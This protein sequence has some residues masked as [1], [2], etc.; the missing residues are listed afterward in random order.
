MDWGLIDLG[1]VSKGNSM[2]LIDNLERIYL[3]I[4]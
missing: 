4:I 2:K 3:I 1:V